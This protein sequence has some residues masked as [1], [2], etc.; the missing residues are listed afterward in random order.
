M[1]TFLR[2]RRVGY[3]LS[4]KKMKKLNFQ[5]FADLCRKRGIEVVQLD[6][7][8]PL[9]D[10]G[11][12]DLI[13][14]K[15]TDLILEADQNDSQAVLQVQRVQDYI[16]AHPE[17][18]V[19]DPLPAIR[20]LLDR[21]KSYQLVHRIE[22]C[23]QDERI[24]SPPFMV[25]NTECTPDVL[26][27]IKLQG[28][29]F[30]FICKTRVAHGTNSHEMAIIFSEEDLK[31]VKPPCVIQSFINHNAV[32]YKVFVVGDSYTV[33]ERPSL[34]NFPAG[35]AGEQRLRSPE[36]AHIH[37]ERKAIFFNSHNVSKPES[38]SD[39]T[40]RENVE[41][42][43]QPPCD[44]VIRELSRSLRQALGVSLFGIDVII[45]NQT[46]QHAVI[47]INAFPGYEGVPEF[48]NDLLSHISGVLQSHN[49]DFVPAGDQPKGL[50]VSGGAGG[51][52]P[53]A[54]CG[55]SSVRGKE[56]QR[57]GCNSA[58]SPNFQQ[59]CVSTIATKASSQ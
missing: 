8:Q 24:C 3:W 54:P 29:T 41:G 48:F 37:T 30:P 52:G 42:V 57:L 1:Q 6:L 12:L 21:C 40:S 2:G 46:G 28:L 10:Q 53:Q 59:H 45:N 51:A 58:V 55:C 22:K 9:E 39:L 35:P 7:S 31:D 38:S 26:E 23:M 32:L 19:L 49:P 44:D 50:T 4:E 25:L 27:Q 13:I 34:K 56:L 43:S 36:A 16:D 5:A 18:I 17:T 15:L 33:V 20:T 47:D 11:P 14:H